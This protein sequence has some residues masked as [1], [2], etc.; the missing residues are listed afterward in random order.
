[1]KRILAPL[2]ILASLLVL[3]GCSLGP[4]PDAVFQQYVAACQKGDFATADTLRT[5][6]TKGGIS[7]GFN[8]ADIEAAWFAR[9]TVENYQ[10]KIDG[11]QA[12]VTFTVT[13]PDLGIIASTTMSNMMGTLFTT[14]LATAFETDETKLAETDALV[15]NMLKSNLI[16]AINDKDAV[17]ATRDGTATLVKVDGSWKIASIEVPWNFGF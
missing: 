4:K 10:T 17:M 6:D 14:A 8:D 3:A 12:T 13:A 1:M 15:E 16:A 5:A 9:V 7:S 11:D 2:T